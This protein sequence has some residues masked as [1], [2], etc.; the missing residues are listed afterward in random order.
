MFK[1]FIAN[2]SKYNEGKLLGEWITLPMADAKLKEVYRK[3]GLKEELEKPFIMDFQTDIKGMELT[4]WSSV[5]SLNE[6]LSEYSNMTDIEK[7]VLQAMLLDGA[8]F[9]DAI[10][11]IDAGRYQVYYECEN[12][13]DVA[14]RV[15]DERLREIPREIAM[16]FDFDAYGRDLEINWNF[17]KLNQNIIQVW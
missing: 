9:E 3:I 5:D 15:M 14:H 16:Y 8:D 7:D 10:K 12:M 11:K 6:F 1:L 4:E 13:T 17:Q 2:I